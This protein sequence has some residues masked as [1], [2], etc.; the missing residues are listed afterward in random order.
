MTYRSIVARDPLREICSMCNCSGL[1]RAYEIIA[2]GLEKVVY[3]AVG[4]TVKVRFE[5]DV[6]IR[7][8][9]GVKRD[10]E[11]TIVLGSSI[12]LRSAD[13]L[14]YVLMHE[15]CHNIVFIKFFNRDF[16][17]RMRVYSKYLKWEHP[18][19]IVCNAFADIA[20]DSCFY[21]SDIEIL[22][23]RLRKFAELI[24]KASLMA[25]AGKCVELA[26]F[27]H[28]KL[29]PQAK[30]VGYALETMDVKRVSEKVVESI[31]SMLE[32]EGYGEDG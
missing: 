10:D 22:D 7:G 28:R 17:R 19:E 16:P 29:I 1:L 14:L 18:E 12:V 32:S 4:V 5:S 20:R 8:F 23:K 26:S 6:R 31:I 11:N 9:V 13:D 24:D 30:D 25:Y 15:A 21:S 27:F 3:K 2:S